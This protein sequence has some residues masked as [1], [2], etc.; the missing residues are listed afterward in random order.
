M[1]ELFTIREVA[2]KLKISVSSAYRY[3]EKG[4]FP[5]LKIGTN[6][7]FTRDHI[8]DFLLGNSIYNKPEEVY[9]PTPAVLQDIYE[10][11]HSQ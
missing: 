11:V 2:E 6:I 3:V 9:T 8:K 4:G 1:E 7:R 5:H 10:M